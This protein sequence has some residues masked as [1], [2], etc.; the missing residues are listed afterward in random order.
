MR[1]EEWPGS[2]RGLATRR[3]DLCPQCVVK[4]LSGFVFI[5]ADGGVGMHTKDAGRRV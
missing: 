1:V 2:S 3:T 5:L 4:Q